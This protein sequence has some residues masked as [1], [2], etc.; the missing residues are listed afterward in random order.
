MQSENNP[1]FVGIS[2]F[3]RLI[4]EVLAKYFQ[5]LLSLKIA[6]EK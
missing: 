6:S 3:L 2:L 4:G 5:N 1:M